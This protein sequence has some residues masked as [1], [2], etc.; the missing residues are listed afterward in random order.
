MKNEELGWRWRASSLSRV[1][2]E[3]GLLS[4]CLGLRRTREFG[5][6]KYRRSCCGVMKVLN[7]G[8]HATTHAKFS[9]DAQKVCL[10]GVVRD[11]KTLCDLL[12]LETPGHESE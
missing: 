11:A 7:R 10:H 2:I 1:K 8:C 6:R 3:F 9:I 5:V 4:Y 12:V